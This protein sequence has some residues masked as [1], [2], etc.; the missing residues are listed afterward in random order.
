MEWSAIPHARVPKSSPLLLD[1]LDH[2]ERVAAFFGGAPFE[3]ASYHAV[4]AA[5]ERFETPRAQL[6]AILKEQNQ[7][8]GG[9]DATLANIRL[10]SEP[11][12]FAVVTGQQVGL[13]SGPVFTLYKALT[14]VRLAQS[15]SERGM[16]CVP[17]FWLAT[18]DHDLE[19]VAQTAALDRADELVELRDDGV[20]PAP[21][22]SVGRAV[23]S[24]QIIT[25]LDRLEKALDAGASRDRL[26]LDLRACYQ[27]GLA[28]G[29]AFGQ[30]VTR[31]FRRWGVVMVDALDES[32]HRLSA[33]TYER[34]IDAAPDLRLRLLARAQALVSAGYHAQVHVG[35]DSTLLFLAEDG[36][37]TAVHQQGHRFVLEG[38]T[39]PIELTVGDLKTCLRDHP[40]R[41]SANALL[42]PIVQDTLLPTLAYIAGPSELAYHG[43][44]QTL[45][46]SF[47]RP[48]PVIFPRASF[49]LV[50]T[51]ARRLMEKYH[52]G[53]EDVWQGEEHLGR[54]IAAA[55]FAEGWSERLDQSE[56][57][58]TELLARLRQD[59]E[60]IDPTL[61]E[62][63]KHVEEKMKYQMER[64]KGKITRAALDRSALLARHQQALLHFVT[65]RRDLQEREI[66]GACF[67]GRAGYELLDR[68]LAQVQTDASD[69]QVL[70]Y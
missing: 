29:Q 28:W 33:A 10:L 24:D 7:A 52:V 66:C 39:G 61:L 68:I 8:F 51:R 45:Y 36:N 67:L 47:G 9:G 64:L 31:L 30:F 32:L 58:L 15:L 12:T 50:D 59:I 48:Q 5:L 46:S 17:V 6:A 35:E 37:R 49:T 25:A 40:G 69:H 11:G 2:Y 20:R 38:A 42:R 13:F 22:C 63:L 16:P 3:T 19:E 1:Y 62:T 70:T 34:A 26:L 41:F 57:D 54:K 4:A 43:Q 27:P 21:R 44:S 56:H 60:T 65:P 14:A 53:V 55:G 18:E 23:F